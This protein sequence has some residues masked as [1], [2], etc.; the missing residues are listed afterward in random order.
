MRR[1]LRHL[2]ASTDRGL[3]EWALLIA[4][5]V[6]SIGF[7]VTAVVLANI[8]RGSSSIDMTLKEQRADAAVS[9][10]VARLT[11]GQ[12]LGATRATSTTECADVSNRSVCYEYWALPIPG[13]ALDPL[14]FDL[15]VQTWI[16]RDRD[17]LPPDAPASVRALKV[18]LSAVTYQTGPGLDPQV[19]GG[20]VQYVA[21]PA[22]PLSAGLFGFRSVTLAG[23]DVTVGSFNAITSGT[24]DRTGTGTVASGG[25]VAFGYGVQV[26]RTLLFASPASLNETTSR[27]TGEPCEESEVAT[28]TEVYLPADQDGRALAWMD[29][30][31]CSQTIDAD[32][33]AS[34]HDGLLPAG[35]TCVNGSAIIDV[36][37]KLAG[38]SRLV[39][40]GS[41]TFAAPINAPSSVENPNAQ[42]L[43]IYSAG[44]GIAFR[45]EMYSDGPLVIAGSIYAPAATCSSDPASGATD[46]SSPGATILYGA[47]ACDTVSLGGAFTQLQDESVF[48]AYTDP[49]PGARKAWS[50]GDGEIVQAAVGSQEGQWDVADGWGAGTCVMP[51]PVS[52]LAYWRLIEPSGVL[53]ADSAGGSY[54][55]TWR[56]ASGGRA[57]GICG[58]AAA[59]D[60]VANAQVSGSATL[61]SPTDGVSLEWWAKAVT[62]AKP[63]VS[64]AGAQLDM[65]EDHV[66]VTAGGRTFRFPFTVQRSGSWHLYTVTVSP[67]GVAT[68]YV[69]GIAKESGAVGSPS[70]GGATSIARGSGGAISDVV[71]YA[72][73]L[74]A[75]EVATRWATWNANV[76]FT[77]AD[78]GT[79]FTAPGAPVD[80][81]SDRHRLAFH[82]APSS[83]TLPPAGTGGAVFE[84]Q[85]SDEQAGTYTTF[86]T[87]DLGTLAYAQDEP[88]AGA[89][90]YRVCTVYNGDSKCSAAT[91]IA[92]IPLPSGTTVT[93]DNAGA[94]TTSVSFSWPFQQWATGAEYQYRLNGGAWSD[95]A[96]VSGTTVAI[97]ASNSAIVEIKVRVVNPAGTGP[98]SD[99]ATG[100]LLP[101]AP[102]VSYGSVTQTTWLGSWSTIPNVDHYVVYCTVGGSAACGTPGVN[103]TTTSETFGP[104]TTGAAFTMKVQAVNKAGVAGPWSSSVGTYLLAGTPS[105]SVTNITTVGATISWSAPGAAKWNF[106]APGIA[107]QN[108]VT[109]TSYAASGS[110][111]AAGAYNICSVNGAGVQSA[112]TSGTITFRALP[113]MSGAV[114]CAGAFSG[115]NGYDIRMTVQEVSQNV[116]A[117]TSVVNWSAYIYA[118]NVSYKP[119]NTGANVNTLN[120][121]INGGSGAWGHNYDFR[122]A[123]VGTTMGIASG[124]VTVGH[125]GNG[126]A[127]MP[128]S[129]SDGSS[130]PLGSASCSG[131][132]TLS[133]LR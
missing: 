16:D 14:A 79:P 105:V 37:T 91:K 31:Q 57:T 77:P 17:G 21:S 86:K 68:L 30:L 111:G 92:T 71:V 94:T 117:N 119:Y 126:N 123:V 56:T 39:V 6:L 72:R 61:S 22:G 2:R 103:R 87:V 11:A 8:A 128:F 12:E 115:R 58:K 73:V 25:P 85:R 67:S 42:R 49:V 46:A 29:G 60:D 3:I 64:A 102:S 99:I 120:V 7:I 5:L 104:T 107:T 9:D 75:S 43:T 52:A 122:N 82:W 62:D 24:S 130:S 66:S 33:I 65:D 36:P 124:S 90:W 125:D 26:D 88:E 108:G 50:I 69:D 28:R 116:A 23:P 129:V 114:T 19:A 15:L 27:C 74:S 44:L 98:W 81:D 47:M 53:A 54:P 118:T 40:H 127:V 100:Y 106:Y 113:A 95:V 93:A 38:V 18:R 101:E 34:Q 131:A 78:A 10:A 70:A 59:L 96:S 51:G 97:T 13:N 20:Q 32:W 48:A 35:T 55:T 63:A 89:F 83:G 84:L 80:E 112:C 132:Y 45:P 121:S 76:V 1:R 109:Y 110:P 133:D 4:L 41:L